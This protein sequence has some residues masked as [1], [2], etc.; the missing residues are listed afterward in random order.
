MVQLN[1]PEGASMQ[2]HLHNLRATVFPHD[3]F[4]HS[5]N[6]FIEALL[7]A[8]ALPLYIQLERRKVQGLSDLQTAN[9]ITA[10]GFI[11]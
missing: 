6:V 1:V 2:E 7:M 11:P 8:Q 5:I 9:L 4:H 10:S 3:E